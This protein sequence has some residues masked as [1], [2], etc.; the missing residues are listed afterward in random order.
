[1]FACDATTGCAG[2]SFRVASASRTL[3]AM[4]IESSVALV[5]G[6][7]R[8]LGRHLVEALLARG[9]TKIYAASRG[10]VPSLP[11]PR[12]VPLALDLTDRVSITAAAARA[13]DVNLLVNNAG[14]FSAGPVLEATEKQLRHDMDVNYYGLLDTIRAFVPALARAPEA[15]IV[16]VLSL[17]SL[18]NWSTFGG[19]SATKAA[20]W[21]LTQALRVEL[22]ERGIKVFAAF[23]G[24]IDTKMVKGYPGDKAPPATIANGILDGVEAGTVDIAPDPFSAGALA[25]YLK[26]PN[27]LIA[28]FAG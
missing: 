15:G 7:N 18:A 16:N 28:N 11:D 9:V 13:G 24:M 22:R 3:G 4:K 2:A 1:M 6:S 25:L 17:V 12:V 26:N 14:V 20:A 27:D 21:S 8:G 10:A 19:Y 23:P 5:T